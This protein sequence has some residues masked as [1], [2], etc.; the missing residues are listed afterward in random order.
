ME[1]VCPR[2]SEKFRCREDRIELCS[3]KKVSLVPGVRDFI[4]EDYEN[5]L[6]PECLKIVNENFNSYGINPRYQ[7]QKSKSE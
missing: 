6:C 2:C 4:K 3:C 7:V 1:K 5:C